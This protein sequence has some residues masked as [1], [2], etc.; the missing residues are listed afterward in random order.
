M[1]IENFSSIAATIGGGFFA[2]ILIGYA[3]LRSIHGGF[4]YLT[5]QDTGEHHCMLH[6]RLQLGR[7]TAH[8]NRSCGRYRYVLLQP[9]SSRAL[10]VRSYSP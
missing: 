6:P 8:S 2:G 9:L 1:S 4:V 3:T 5:Q 10:R 7:W